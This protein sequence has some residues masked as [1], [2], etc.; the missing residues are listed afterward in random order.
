M[1][2]WLIP[3]NIRRLPIFVGQETIQVRLGETLLRTYVV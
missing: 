1:V 3:E 2:F